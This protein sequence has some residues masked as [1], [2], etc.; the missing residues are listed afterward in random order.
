MRF[1]NQRTNRP[2][3]E[4]IEQIR[5]ALDGGSNSTEEIAIK[6]GLSLKTVQKYASLE[7]IQL[8]PARSIRSCVESIV[9]RGVHDLDAIIQ[10]AI[11]GTSWSPWRIATQ[12]K[13]AASE[14]GITLTGG[15]NL[16]SAKPRGE[17][18]DGLIKQGRKQKEIGEAM[19][20]VTSEYARQYIHARGLYD[21]WI[22]AKR[23]QKCIKNAEERSLQEIRGGLVSLLRKRVY[24]RAKCEGWA[25][26]K[27]V[28]YFFAV[29]TTLHFDRIKRVFEGYQ[30][31]C[32]AGSKVSVET[33][34]TDAKISPM[35]VWRILRETG[36]K[37]LNTYS[38]R[39]LTSAKLTAIKRSERVS[40]S[41]GD[42]A[43]FV[44]V[45][46]STVRNR[47]HSR[48]NCSS[49]VKSLEFGHGRGCSL[50]TASQ[51]YEAQDAGL[52]NEEI[53]Q[54]LDRKQATVDNAIKQREWTEPEIV[55]ALRKLYGRM[56]INQPYKNLV[57][58]Q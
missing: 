2:Y 53:S 43:Y 5:R 50:G 36:L 58:L 29:D 56:D 40:L 15:K 31:A 7:D 4:R 3:H 48:L 21:D 45:M 38:K 17:Y 22:E 42:V 39:R 14:M 47:R 27:A 11:K 32:H 6:V 19:G 37:T 1:S 12:A 16:H 30:D 9:Q 18:V 41:D 34:G 10:G 52:A 35:A 26:E 44:G 51:I 13:V 33:L 8:P 28:E 46:E 55:H 57:F 23:E 20:G 54:L 49:Y 25:A 24:Q